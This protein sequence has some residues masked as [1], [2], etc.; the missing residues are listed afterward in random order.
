G[1]TV[2]MVTHEPDMAEFARRVVRFVDGR[3][4]SDTGN[5]GNH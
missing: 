3:V 5:G 4:E 1:I 2:L